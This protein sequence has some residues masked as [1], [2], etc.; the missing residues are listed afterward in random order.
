MILLLHSFMYSISCI[1]K[2]Y[3]NYNRAWKFFH[4]I[5]LSKKQRVYRNKKLRIVLLLF[6]DVIIPTNN[7]FIFRDSWNFTTKCIGVKLKLL[8][9][10]FVP[11][12][13]R[14]VQKVGSIYYIQS[15]CKTTSKKSTDSSC[16]FTRSGKVWKGRER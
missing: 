11:L 4:K 14:K 8:V 2:K 15:D 7:L 10:F 3:M 6:T 5:K 12:V 1:I 16:V 13:M 9:L